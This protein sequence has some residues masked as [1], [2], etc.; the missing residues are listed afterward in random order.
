MIN[1]E[2]KE[3]PRVFLRVKAVVIDSIMLLIFMLIAFFI[4]SAFPDAPEEIRMA[5]FI[6]IFGLYDPLFTSI[7][8]GTFGHMIIG[9]RVK[10]VR[11]ENKN[12]IFPLALIRFILKFSL[13]WVSLLTVMFNKKG[14]AIHDM[15]VNSV[16]VFYRKP[17][18]TSQISSNEEAMDKDI[19]RDGA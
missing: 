11:N 1:D 10:R 13:G 19:N 5:V 9:I 8:G 3:Y 6:F 4:F 17:E 7:F 12:I 16:V 2:E 14:K 18:L 15:V